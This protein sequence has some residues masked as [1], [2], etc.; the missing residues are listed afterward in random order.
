[1]LDWDQERTARF[2]HRQTSEASK[3]I[4]PTGIKYSCCDKPI[5]NNRCFSHSDIV[6]I[7]R[8]SYLNDLNDLKAL[9]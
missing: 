5:T 1:M 8:F 7:E 3:M 4:T 9:R 2:G 6:N